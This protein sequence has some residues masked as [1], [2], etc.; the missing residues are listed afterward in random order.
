[1]MKAP[2]LPCPAALDSVLSTAAMPAALAVA[3]G[4]P[5]VDA[6]PAAPAVVAAVWKKL[7]K[8]PAMSWLPASAPELKTF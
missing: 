6:T 4:T 5:V 7:L 1:M 8:A 3:S 2:A